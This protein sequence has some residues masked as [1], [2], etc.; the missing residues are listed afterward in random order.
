MVSMIPEN[1]VDP[2]VPKGDKVVSAPFKITKITHYN[3]N[4]NIYEFTLGEVSVCSN[5]D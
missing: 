2:L 3:H 4:T 1:G 5:I